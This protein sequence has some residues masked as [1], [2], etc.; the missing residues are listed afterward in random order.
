MNADKP[1]RVLQLIASEY[2]GGAER[3]VIDLI[4]AFPDTRLESSLFVFNRSDQGL[5]REGMS[6]T[7]P[8]Y[9]RAENFRIYDPRLWWGSRT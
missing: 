5:L 1:I 9:Q 4:Q 2:G 6:Q 7:T 8:R 3:L